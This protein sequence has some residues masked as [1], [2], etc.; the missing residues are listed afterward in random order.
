MGAEVMAPLAQTL[1]G[2]GAVG[3]VLVWFMFRNEA[4]GVKLWEAMDRQ[5]GAQDR[6][7]RAVL[8]LMISNPHL[9]PSTRDEASAIVREIDEVES[10]QKARQ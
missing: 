4:Q 6:Q 7:T 9:S 10:Q 5:R 1:F 8:L 2:T 3:A